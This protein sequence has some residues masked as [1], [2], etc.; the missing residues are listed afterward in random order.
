M[1]PVAAWADTLEL[2][3]TSYEE[4]HYSRARQLFTTVEREHGATPETDFYLGRLALWFDEGPVALAHLERAART[5][6]NEARLQNALGDAYGMTAQTVS[7]LQKLGWARKSLAAYSRAVELEPDNTQWR[8]SLFG[9]YCVA[10]TIAGG[11]HHR[12]KQAALEIEKRDS[13]QGR[14]ALATLALA[15]KRY[16]HAF[17]LFEPIL[18]QS[19]DDYIALFQYGRCAAISGLNIERGIAALQ[20]Y[21]AL[22]PAEREGLPTREAVQYRLANLL[23]K[24][25]D[26]STAHKLYQDIKRAAP[27]FRADKVALRH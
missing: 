9:F 21:L 3:V 17:A 27:D 12:A 8:W 18:D 13:S 20:H 5:R 15:E 2:A 23:E 1:L 11:G 25:G 22:Q 7:L 24:K 26:R 19:P 4:R 6:G 16:I 10:P 14:V